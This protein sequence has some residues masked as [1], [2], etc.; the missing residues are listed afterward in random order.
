M[1]IPVV[2]EPLQGRLRVIAGDMLQKLA[3]ECATFRGQICSN[4]LS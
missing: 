4:A 3:L 1:V 2:Q